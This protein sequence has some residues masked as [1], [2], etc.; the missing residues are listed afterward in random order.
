MRRFFVILITLAI[1][2]S[3]V[4][5]VAAG[6]PIRIYYAGPEENSVFTALTARPQ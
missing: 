4:A 6:N 3:F 5:P 2:F 1:L